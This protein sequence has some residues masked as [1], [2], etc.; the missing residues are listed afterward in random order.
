MNFH[1]RKVYFKWG[2]NT[3]LFDINSVVFHFDDF[4]YGRRSQPYFFK[5]LQLSWVFFI[6]YN[7]MKKI[8]STLSKQFQHSIVV[9]GNDCT[10]SC[11][12]NYH[13]STTAQV[14]LRWKVIVLLILMEFMI[15]TVYK[16]SF[17]TNQWKELVCWKYVFCWGSFDG[18]CI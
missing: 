9:I 18:I 12:F 5:Q 17:H 4:N 14:Q 16:L 6:T 3:S 10:G 15:I 13:T 2:W 1:Q 7:K 11:K 8:Y